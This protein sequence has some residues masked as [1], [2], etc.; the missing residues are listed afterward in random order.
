VGLCHLLKSFCPAFSLTANDAHSC[1]R[2]I[3]R[4]KDAIMRAGSALKTKQGKNFS[5]GGKG[6]PELA[7]V[8]SV[9]LVV[10]G[11]DGEEDFLARSPA[12]RKLIEG[13]PEF[14]FFA[15]MLRIFPTPI[16]DAGLLHFLQ[17]AHDPV[18]PNGPTAADP[19]SRTGNCT[20]S[21]GDD[22]ICRALPETA[23]PR[24]PQRKPVPAR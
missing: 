7:S 20:W 2:W 15:R 12:I 24:W 13:L 18:R 5:A 11:P 1:N 8:E 6:P 22:P 10:R 23:R 19:S 17:I 4:V 14:R 3:S 9:V 16:S 21:K